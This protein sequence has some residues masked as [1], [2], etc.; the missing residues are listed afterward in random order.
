MADI[1]EELRYRIESLERR[2]R[3]GRLISAALVV[4]ILGLSLPSWRSN[5]Q[6]PRIVRVRTLIVEDEQGRDRVVLGAPVPDLKGGRRISPSVG[7]VINDSDGLERFGL[8]LQSNGRMVMGFDAPPG[9]GDPRNRERINIVADA[10][11]GAYIRFVNRKTF[12]PGRLVLD[13]RDQFYLEFLDFPDG[14]TVG[15]RIGFK[16]EER[17]EHTR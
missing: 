12:V 15:R 11:G 2:V 8:G 17:V 16:G 1:H 10:S 7:L 13:D 5:A 4:G 14:K 6:D 9:T 3:S